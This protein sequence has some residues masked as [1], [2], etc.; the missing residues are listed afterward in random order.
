[1][2]WRLAGLL[3]IYGTAVACSPSETSEYGPPTTESFVE[4]ADRHGAVRAAPSPATG[5]STVD[6]LRS[7][8]LRLPLD[9]VDVERTKGQF[10]ERR[11]S[12]SRSH[13][14]VDLLA[15]RGT[16][17]HAVER[18]TIQKLFLSAAGGNTVYQ[19]DPA[20]RFCYYYAHLDRYEAGLREG[21]EVATGEVIGY[22][23]TSGNA[24]PN[25]PHLHFAIFEL[26]PERRWWQGRPIDP[27]TV[28][29]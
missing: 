6:E 4:P 29:H 23:G 12:G 1:M 14:A 22:V 15:P 27:Y 8:H 9:G 28:F 11:G 20:G 25:T 16:P 10:A 26:G 2:M 3:V 13:E 5:L 19:F 7:R 18:G 17:V 21:H 24:P